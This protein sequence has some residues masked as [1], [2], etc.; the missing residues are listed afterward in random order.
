MLERHQE[1]KISRPEYS[2]SHWVFTR[3]ILFV[4]G[5][6]LVGIVVLWFYQ[7]IILA[8]GAILLA[9][10]IRALSNL[11]TSLGRMPDA[12][13]LAAAV[14][15][16]GWLFGSQLATQFNELSSGLPESLSVLQQDISSTSWG[17][18]LVDQIKEADLSG[19]TAQIASHIAA[20]FGSAF[21]AL[22]YTAVL[23]FSA[24][25]LALQPCATETRPWVSLP[26]ERRNR[27]AEIA[28]LT[29]ATLKRWIVGQ[30]VPMAFVGFFSDV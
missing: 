20:F 25:Y 30:A 17:A 6:L 21:R 19:A 27:I 2:A 26:S 1:R 22:A 11:L 10:A 16:V 15:S 12:L 24:V 28:D 4:F 5:L 9:L 29:G 13:L 18:W 3:N 23:L 8:F 7:T 14:A